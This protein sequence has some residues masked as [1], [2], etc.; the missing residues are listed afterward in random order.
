M[1]TAHRLHQKID[2]SLYPREKGPDVRR[3]RRAPTRWCQQCRLQNSHVVKGTFSPAQVNAAVPKNLHMTHNSGH[4]ALLACLFKVNII[5]Q[6]Q[7]VEM[8]VSKKLATLA[9]LRSP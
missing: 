1:Q 4:L 6:F 3:V 9:W 7:Y 8:R 5:Y 2:V